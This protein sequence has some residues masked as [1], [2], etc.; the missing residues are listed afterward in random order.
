MCGKV[1]VLNKFSNLLVVNSDIFKAL[2]L[3]KIIVKVQSRKI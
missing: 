2:L 3:V 1:Y